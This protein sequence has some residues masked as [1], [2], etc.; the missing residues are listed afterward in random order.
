MLLFIS[1]SGVLLVWLIII[2]YRTCSRCFDRI[3]DSPPLPNIMDI[4]ASEPSVVMCVA[5]TLTDEKCLTRKK[6]DQDEDEALVDPRLESVTLEQVAYVDDDTDSAP[7]AVST[8]SLSL[9]NPRTVDMPVTRDYLDIQR[10]EAAMASTSTLIETDDFAE[11]F[12]TE[13]NNHNDGLTADKE[14]IS[15]KPAHVSEGEDSSSQASKDLDCQVLENSSSPTT[16]QGVPPSVSA[17]IRENGETPGS[18]ETGE[19]ESNSSN[20]RRGSGILSRIRQSF[21]FRR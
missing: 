20:S 3:V 12:S 21:S 4:A 19:I 5:G 8:L 2:V 16:T 18:S 9:E 13:S 17:T 11:E 6:D 14:S 10:N 7:M 1:F 15:V